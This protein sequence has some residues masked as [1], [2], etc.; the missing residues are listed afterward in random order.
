MLL[1]KEL[2]HGGFEPRYA[3]VDSLA[4]LGT[5]LARGSWGLVLVDAFMPELEAVTV[6][7]AV[8]AHD[9]ELPVI[10]ISD[11]SSDDGG[12]AAIKAGACDYVPRDQFD[13]LRAA[14][15]RELQ[16]FE[17]RKARKRVQAEARRTEELLRLLVEAS[18]EIITVLGPDGTIRY[19][20]ASAERGL[21]YRPEELT[22]VNAIQFIHEDDQAAFRKVLEEVKS[23]PGASQSVELRFRHKDG[24]WRTLDCLSKNLMD[25]PGVTGILF[26]A[27]DITQRRHAGPTLGRAET[28]DRTPTDTTVNRQP[29]DAAQ[30][31]AP[32]V[33]G[34]P[35]IDENL[36]RY[37][38]IQ[39][40]G[41]GGMGT[42]YKAHDP[43]LDRLVAV[44]V[45][46]FDVPR[47]DLAIVVQRFLREARSAA[48]VRHPNVCPI[49]DV[50][51]H[52]GVPF[53]VMAYVEGQ[54]LAEYLRLMR[55]DADL[56]ESVRLVRQVA[57]GLRAVHS[58]GI[59][60][61]DL[62]PANILLDKDG[63]PLLT[64][65]GLARPENETQRLTMH[66]AVIGTPGY[67]APEQ[68]AGE[69]ERIGAPTDIYSLGVLL[70]VMLTSRLPYQGS[71]LTVL[72]KQLDE[73]PPPPSSIRAGLDPE[74]EG[75]VLKA[76][77]RKPEDRYQS[78]QQLID[79]FDHWLANASKV[80][81]A[82]TVENASP[83]IPRG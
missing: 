68:A 15:E 28:R 12:V 61:R 8:H 3:R 18:S 29:G 1:V 21:G 27:R 36:G 65:F 58:H 9:S 26:D 74:L 47:S 60:H 30:R 59:V 11:G 46:R 79:V 35:R 81:A 49:Y 14:I 34:S 22:G 20:T 19:G 42:V 57:V 62:K 52:D 53:V 6:I 45:P 80:A 40:L 32:I 41:E 69:A 71:A 25:H 48:Q 63:Q 7:Q 55:P 66:G 10:V 16:Q 24:S 33:R 17:E 50:D 44:K 37:R 54:S 38:L 75:I 64:D 82:T 5:E 13:K 83:K 39:M 76:M 70:Y 78:A 43:K 56:A 72:L 23:G 51:E 4:T 67:M 2:R 77:A 31:N 73:P